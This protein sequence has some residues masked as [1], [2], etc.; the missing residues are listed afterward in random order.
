MET[1]KVSIVILSHLSDVQN[2][3][4]LGDM[5]AANERINF[6]KYLTLTYKDNSVEIDPEAVFEEFKKKHPSL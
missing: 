6:V 2:M 3:L 1:I 4:H 5:V